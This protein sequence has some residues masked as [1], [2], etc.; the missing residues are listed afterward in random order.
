MKQRILL[1]HYTMHETHTDP[2]DYVHPPDVQ[3]PLRAPRIRQYYDPRHFSVSAAP[4]SGR[5]IPHRMMSDPTLLE[6][7][8]VQSNGNNSP[9]ADSNDTRSKSE[10]WKNSAPTLAPPSHPATLGRLQ[11]G[12]EP[13][14]RPVHPVYR[15]EPT[16]E[17]QY[18]GRRMKHHQLSASAEDLLWSGNSEGQAGTLV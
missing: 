4:S 14:N 8:T 5:Q 12:H 10:A 6:T 2:L 17:Q 18:T 16:Y 11:E 9:Q 7:K 15:N 13:R 1:N 3:A